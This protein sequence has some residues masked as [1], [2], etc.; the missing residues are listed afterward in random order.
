[1]PHDAELRSSLNVAR[2]YLALYRCD[3]DAAW[4]CVWNLARRRPPDLPAAVVAGLVGLYT[5]DLDRL[6]VG[7]DAC[8]W[9]SS[10]GAAGAS[11]WRSW[12]YADWRRLFR[13]FGELLDGR[14][15][16]ARLRLES[17]ELAPSGFEHQSPL[18]VR[19]RLQLAV[20]GGDA[21]VIKTRVSELRPFLDQAAVPPSS[22]ERLA[23]DTTPYGAASLNLL[24]AD[25][26]M[27]EGRLVDAEEAVHRALGFAAPQLTLVVVD[28]LEALAVVLTQRNRLADA[29][30]L[31]GAMSAFRE[32]SGMRFRFPLRRI[33]LE[34]LASQM[35]E[36]VVAAGRDLTFTEAL[37]VAHGSRG[38]RGRPSFGWDSLTPM[39]QRVVELVA[40]GR[41]N[42]EIAD[43]LFIGV[44]TVKT[45]LV[46]VYEKLGIG[47]RTELAA[48]T[49]RKEQTC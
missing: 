43:K 25:V 31:L 28:A 42:A 45:H 47:S 15:G 2:G 32:Q 29:G 16:E 9:T 13:A 3:F 27:S 34:A 17:A 33:Q 40:D 23:R 22:L 1:L 5:E 10:P 41:S 44:S 14:L 24:L 4:Q 46:H 30:R 6:A 18:S 7:L 21:E 39:E 48:V 37:S 26:A 36:S 20:L 8:E 11:G 19:L 49:A 12:P 35:E 38:K